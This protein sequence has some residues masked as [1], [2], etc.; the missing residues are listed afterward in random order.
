[1]MMAG[2]PG[3]DPHPLLNSAPSYQ[4]PISSGLMSSLAPQ[5]VPDYTQMALQMA[6]NPHAGP[7]AQ[8]A[9]P[10]GV[11]VPGSP[12]V[13]SGTSSIGAAAGG[14][15]SA[16]AQNPSLLKSGVGLIKGLFG[17]DPAT[18]AGVTAPSVD[19]INMPFDA[20]AATAGALPGLLAAL[21]SA[22]APAGVVSVG[23]PAMLGYG[24]TAAAPAASAAG[25]G[26]AAAAAASAAD[27]LTP[28]VPTASY[29]AAPAASSAAT[30]AG[31]GALGGGLLAGGL[32]LAPIMAGMLT[33]AVTENAQYYSNLANTLNQGT[34][35]QG[36]AFIPDQQELANMI[37]S[38]RPTPYT[39]A[40]LNQWGIPQIIAGLNQASA[41]PQ[42]GFANQTVSNAAPVRRY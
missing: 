40:Q 30:G 18:Q 15:L 32:A 33:P 7:Y 39:Q 9:P 36:S 42:N 26:A 31:M 38:G 2:G 27:G 22:A 37:M 16:L 29:M 20:A 5:G 25:G 28:I 23:A 14:L 17:G 6:G 19:P 8:T 41:N 1:M 3:G 10:S 11:G 12:G 4:F 13:T 21:P 34:T 35:G 24:A